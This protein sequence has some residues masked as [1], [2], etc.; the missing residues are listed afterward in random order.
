MADCKIVNAAVVSAISNIGGATQ[1]THQAGQHHQQQK[2][3]HPSF[4][5][6]TF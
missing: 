5:I 6:H 3:R 1:G 2:H 4:Q